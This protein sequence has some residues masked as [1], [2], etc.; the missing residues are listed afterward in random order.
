V[1]EREKRE[2]FKPRRNTP[3]QLRLRT[4]L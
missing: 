1:G 2:R 4:L 3:I